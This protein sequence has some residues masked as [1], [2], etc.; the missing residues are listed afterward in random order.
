MSLEVQ[1]TKNSNR[2]EHI[3][4]ALALES[5]RLERRCRLIAFVPPSSR[6]QLDGDRATLAGTRK[7]SPAGKSCED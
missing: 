6:D 2:A 5:G 1:N 4:S 3:W 7:K